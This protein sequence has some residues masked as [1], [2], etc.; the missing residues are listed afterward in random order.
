MPNYFKEIFDLRKDNEHEEKIVENI[1][2]NIEFKGANL[3][4]LIFAIFIASIGLNLNSVP[5]IIGAMLISPLMGPIVGLGLALGTNDSI[6]L[7]RSARSLGIATVIS[8]GISTL[9][10]YLSPINN[11]Q[12]ELLARTS[13]TIYD[14]LIAFFGGLAGIVGSTR[15]EK[16]NVIPGVAI[17][18]ALMPPLCTVGYG[19]AT[20]QSAF[21]LG[22]SY[23]F[24][25]NCLFICLATLIGVKYLKLPS[26]QV[27]D[28]AKAV[29]TRRAIAVA[30][31]IMIV[32][33]VYFAYTFVQENNF[34]VNVDRYLQEEFRNQ[35]YTIVYQ[36]VSYKS[37]P[38]TIE[39][40][41]FSK[42]FTESEIQEAQNALATYGLLNTE[43]VIRQREAVLSE[44]EWQNALASMQSESEKILALEA[45]LQE[46]QANKTE[47]RQI[48][49]EAQ[50]IN[51]KISRVAFGELETASTKS[52]ST[53]SLTED[54]AMVTLFYVTP[55]TTTIQERQNKD[56][57]QTTSELAPEEQE[58]LTSWIRLR[59]ENKN[60]ETYFIYSK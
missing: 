17:A 15:R 34:K 18:T 60:M 30:V 59:L 14:V 43:L 9:Y 33:A 37:S 38:R 29:S 10:F 8:V 11:I 21:F 45:K 58:Q 42:E 16:S 19:I 12:S 5:V 41:F 39:L 2:K 52:A 26:V 3:W 7:R 20:G 4:T 47:T 32:P 51:S 57:V 53:T 25:I 46:S 49:N 48:L 55:A 50:L 56:V 1:H 35:G 6:L 54:R 24:A 36:D 44:E 13:P 28:T 23:L 31:I 40:A 22:A 27:V